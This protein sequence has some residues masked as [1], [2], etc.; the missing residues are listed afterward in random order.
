ME[1]KDSIEFG[2]IFSI[3]DEIPEEYRV[4]KRALICEETAA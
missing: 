2:L 4:K 1:K 3:M